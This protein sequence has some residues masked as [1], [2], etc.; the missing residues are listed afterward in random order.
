M[1]K[2]NSLFLQP[3]NGSSGLA[4]KFLEDFKAYATFQNLTNEKRKI[5]CF[6]LNLTGTAKLWFESLGEFDNLRWNIIENSFINRFIRPNDK[7]QSDFF[8]E[9]QIFDCLKLAPNQKVEDFFTILNEKAVHLQKQDRDIMTKFING[10][11]SQLAFFVRASNPQ[12]SE[13]ALTSARSGDAFGYRR[14]PTIELR[15][16]SPQCA[17]CHQ[18]YVP[19]V[20]DH[21]LDGITVNAVHNQHVTNHGAHNSQEEDRPPHRQNSR[22]HERQ[23]PQHQYSTQQRPQGNQRQQRQRG[24]P[25]N[26]EKFCVSCQCNGHDRFSCNL[27]PH[28][29]PKSHIQCQLCNQFGHGARFCIQNRHLNE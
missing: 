16:T 17:S 11:P 18:N 15:H 14:E 1:D 20:V 13:E 6:K 12:T 23:P 21:S 3:F 26:R 22:P 7:N 10:L 5:A 19:S 25:L 9:E 28:A 24:R 8:L 2:P 29:R 27:V 4:R